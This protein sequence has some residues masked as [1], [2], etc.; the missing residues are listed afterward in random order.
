MKETCRR[1]HLKTLF[2]LPD[3]DAIYLEAKGYGM[4]PW[5]ISAVI[6]EESHCSPDAVSPVGAV[7]LMQLM[8]G[9]ADAMCRKMNVASPGGEGLK[10]CGFN[11]PIG[12]FYLRQLLK[13]HGGRLAF[14]LAEYNAGPGGL[15]KW[16]AGDMPD[17]YFIENID[18]AE[19]RGYVK[20]VLRNYFM[21]K[22]LYSPA[23]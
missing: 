17:D 4:D 3:W 1:R 9:T 15:A 11:I 19:T 6:R 16:K 2:P 22:K 23:P 14:V 7:G 18:Y 21:Y 5:L 20:K 8:E 13:K 12:S 10:N